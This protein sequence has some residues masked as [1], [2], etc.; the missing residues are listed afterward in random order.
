[1]QVYNQGW[2]PDPPTP[3][4]SDKQG[5]ID[6]T[7]KLLAEAYEYVQ[8]LPSNQKPK[9]YLDNYKRSVK[10]SIE[11][12]KDGEI[13]DEELFQLL[14]NSNSILVNKRYIGGRKT[15]KVKRSHKRKT[16]RHRR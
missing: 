3:T 6:Y 2:K 7:L 5:K 1:M 16:R 11:E 15:R 8:T 14:E 12:N 9:K 4:I 13:S 10:G